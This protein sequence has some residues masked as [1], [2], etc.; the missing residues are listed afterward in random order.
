MENYSSNQ[1]TGN[2]IEKDLFL[3]QNKL[4]FKKYRPL[5]QIG[6]GTFSTVYAS[7][8][9]KTSTYVAIKVEKRTQN[10]IELLESEAFFLYSL[11]GFGIPEVLSYGRT[12]TH[13]ILVLPLLGNSLLDI[14]I[15]MNSY[16]NINDICGVAIQILDRIEWVHSNNIV[17]RDIKPENFLFGRK[18]NDV[19]YLIDFG[20]CRKFKSSK[21]GRHIVPK[22]LGKFTG[23]S[24]YASVYAM[25]GNEQSRRDDIESIGYMIIFFMK[26]RLPWQGIKCK[27]YKESYYKLY[28]MKKY[29]KIEELCKGLPNEIIE[30]MNYAK[31]LKFEQEPDYKYLKNL[32]KIIF[33][34]NNV[35]FDKYI[36]S[37]CRKDNLKNKDIKKSNIKIERKSSPQ[38]RLYKKIQEIIENKNKYIPNSNLNQISINDK[39]KNNTINSYNKNEINS[40]ISNT[41]KVMINKNINSISNDLIESNKTGLIRINSDKNVYNDKI[42]SFIGNNDSKKYY[43]P[44]YK[45][46]HYLS[47]NP[48]VSD[49]KISKEIQ[50]NNIRKKNNILVKKV[51]MQN[52]GNKNRKIIHIS[53]ISNKRNINSLYYMN[54]D[55]NN[56]KGNKYNKINQIK[57]TSI[58][59]NNINKKNNIISNNNQNKNENIIYNTYN[60]YNTFNS[61]NNTIDK[62]INNNINK[63]YQRGPEEIHNYHNYERIKKNSLE[64]NNINNIKVN[65]IHNVNINNVNINNVNIN[66]TNNMINFISPLVEKNA[67]SLNNIYRGNFSKDQIKYSSTDI[68]LNLN[69][70]SNNYKNSQKIINRNNLNNKKNTVLKY[71]NP[72]ST[73]L[74]GYI[75]NVNKMNYNSSHSSKKRNNIYINNV[76]DYNISKLKKELN[77]IKNYNLNSSKFLNNIDNRIINGKINNESIQNINKNKLNY[78]F[79]LN[80]NKNKLNNQ[81]T[82]N[83]QININNEINIHNQNINSINNKI[84]NKMNKSNNQNKKVLKLDKI[85][86]SF[87]NIEKDFNNNYSSINIISE[88]KKNITPRDMLYPTNN[89]NNS[90]NHTLMPKGQLNNRIFHKKSGTMFIYKNK[91]PPNSIINKSY[92]SN[93]SSFH[94]MSY[95]QNKNQNQNG[96]YNKVFNDKSTKNNKPLII[97]M[98]PK[99]LSNHSIKFV[100]NSTYLNKTNDNILINNNNYNLNRFKTEEISLENKVNR[101]TKYKIIRNKPT[102]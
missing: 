35:R 41:M 16:V 69:T 92:I 55:I 60:T 57:I 85:K 40:E 68:M 15:I 2:E 51:N 76:D 81:N 29:M 93:N 21:T 94:N 37:W 47:L 71:N 73:P 44:D 19:L 49:M 22:S 95:N 20:L 39:S 11:R 52:D 45:I 1:N 61:F 87:N 102:H 5:K 90:Y 9:I 24:R 70:P 89:T 46:A 30:Y 31:S 64:I 28:L 48:E 7:I 77:Y 99:L 83:N 66:N 38:N 14:F 50:S 86:Y 58:K 65:K 3:H 26:K 67:K 78:V 6:K 27:S 91:K 54:T 8:N 62:S 74:I 12:K 56:N 18:D 23:T 96:Y 59:S 88:T 101:I 98:E 34:K 17:Y 75:K 79:D 63:I 42:F 100:N 32:F 84:K 72:F 43:S 13:N 36:Y 33:K 25:A 97:R 4:L 80:R 10:D 53:P 82:V